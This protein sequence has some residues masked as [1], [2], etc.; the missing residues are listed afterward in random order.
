MGIFEISDPGRI[1]ALYAGWPETFI[2]SF[3]QGYMGSA[4]ADHPRFPTSAKIMVGDFCLFAGK[5]NAA[6]ILHQP[7]GR[8]T[9]FFILVPQNE[10]WGREIERILGEQAQRITRYAT[11]KD[12][13]LFRRGKLERFAALSNPNFQLRSIDGPLFCLLRVEEWSRDLCSQFADY[14]DY[15]RSGIG[16]AALY[17]GTPVAGA[18]SYTGYRGC[19]EIEIDTRGDFRRQGLATACGARLIL[20][21]LDCGLYPSWDAHSRASLALSKKLGY[22]LDRPYPAY[23]WNPGLPRV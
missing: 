2:W 10:A 12:P 20:D 4:W 18:S 3:L 5:P 8:E 22:K 16:V 19:I 14:A 7:E 6:L 9:D 13:S 21:C 1:E 11:Q 17:Q 23:E 15:E